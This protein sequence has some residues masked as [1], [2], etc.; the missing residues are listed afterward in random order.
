MNII[1]SLRAI[2]LTSQD[3]QYKKLVI[4]F[5]NKA[6]RM[7]SNPDNYNYKGMIGALEVGSGSAHLDDSFLNTLKRFG[8]YSFI[9]KI[10]IDA[11]SD[12][13]E[14]TESV[15][16]REKIIG[17]LFY[18]F[19]YESVTGKNRVSDDIKQCFE[20]LKVKVKAAGLVPVPDKVVRKNNVA[21][22]PTTE[23]HTYDEMGFDQFAPQCEGALQ[24]YEFIKN[25]KVL[26]KYPNIQMLKNAN[27]PLNM[28]VGFYSTQLLYWASSQGI[29][30]G[31]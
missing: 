29:Q 20:I 12:I 8:D 28:G 6:V 18:D 10:M 14:F 16:I 22:R 24:M 27:D 15:E 3:I 7:F 19:V 30:L 31:G 5:T 1:K 25:H 11:F 9:E 21:R 13:E 17:Q 26:K 23:R 4:A 2:P